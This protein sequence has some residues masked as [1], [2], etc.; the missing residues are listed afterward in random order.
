MLYQK[1]AYTPLKL[2]ST[3][4]FMYL[5]VTEGLDSHRLRSQGRAKSVCGKLERMEIGFGSLFPTQL[6]SI[7]GI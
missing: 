1:V 4:F 6:L 7:S 3:L 2:N 5:P